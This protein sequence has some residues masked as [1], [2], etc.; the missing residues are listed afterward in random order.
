MNYPTLV[1]NF[2]C[3]ATTFQS[4]ASNE[5][6]TGEAFPNNCRVQSLLT[7]L[8]ILHSHPSHYFCSDS[9]PTSISQH[10]APGATNAFSMRPRT[11]T[12]PTC[13]SLVFA[14]STSPFWNPASHLSPPIAAA[15]NDCITLPSIN[16]F[17]AIWPLSMQ[18]IYDQDILSE[19]PSS[20]DS[21]SSQPVPLLFHSVIGSSNTRSSTCS[22]LLRAV[23]TRSPSLIFLLR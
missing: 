21:F 2:L 15:M 6:N 5:T 13:S 7:A 4:S 1:F 20:S 12:H 10:A 23:N 11:F 8:C 16:T 14:L 17:D 9:I 22:D 18:I 19:Y 3:F